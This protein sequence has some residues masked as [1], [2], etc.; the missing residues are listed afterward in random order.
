MT[1]P[2]CH[3]GRWEPNL[4]IQINQ[5]RMGLALS[6]HKSFLEIL[7]SRYLIDTWQNF[8]V[9]QLSYQAATWPNNMLEFWPWNRYKDEGGDGGWLGWGESTSS[10]CCLLLGLE[11]AESSAPPLP[12]P[13]HMSSMPSSGITTCRR[14]DRKEDVRTVEPWAF[15]TFNIISLLFN[16]KWIFK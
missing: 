12:W 9:V 11:K 13:G 7:V 4:W 2:S 8:G 14:G 1:R 15:L 3:V 16:Q 5:S 6:T 10:H